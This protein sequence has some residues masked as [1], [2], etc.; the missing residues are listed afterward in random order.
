MEVIISCT[1]IT[2]NIQYIE[3]VCSQ[4]LKQG[5]FEFHDQVLFCLRE[6]LI[7]AVASSPQ[8]SELVIK[9]CITENNVTCEVCNQLE[10][11]KRFS[12]HDQLQLRKLDDVGNAEHGRGLLMIQKLT[13]RFWQEKS[14]AQTVILI[15][16]KRGNRK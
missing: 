6:L 8:K 13:D 14:S 16:E 12:L 5:E 7:N 3:G 2:A 1:S 10:G 4:T 9:F 11:N 15:F